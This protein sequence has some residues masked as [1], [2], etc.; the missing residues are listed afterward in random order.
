MR[1]ISRFL[2]LR[3]AAMKNRMGL[4]ADASLSFSMTS[5]VRRCPI[6]QLKRLPL[7]SPLRQCFL[8]KLSDRLLIHPFGPVDEEISVRATLRPAVPS[9]DFIF[10]DIDAHGV[11]AIVAL[12]EKP[13][14]SD[15]PLTRQ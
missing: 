6:L 15:L 10:G 1:E 3:N 7:F 12:S 5:L 13:L 2:C 9:R 11:R 4:K 14:V 8:D